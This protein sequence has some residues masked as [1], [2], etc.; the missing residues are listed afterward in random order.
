MTTPDRR[1]E[2]AAP[3][4]L[5]Y[6]IEIAAPPDAVWRSI[7]DPEWTPRFF[8]NTAVH[9]RWIVGQPITYDLPTGETAISGTLVE[10]DPPRRFVMTARFHFD[11]IP[12]DEPDSRL[13]WEVTPHGAG[14]LL[15]LIHDRLEKSPITLSSVR[16]GWPAILGG[17]STMLVPGSSSQVGKSFS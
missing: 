6:T 4:R 7:T 10:Y 2:G 13:S 1:P 16:G 5:V 9:S 12:L 14:A 11:N 17:I 8:H 3:N 15:T